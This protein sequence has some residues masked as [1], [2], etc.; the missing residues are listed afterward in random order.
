MHWGHAVSR[1]LVHWTELPIALYP[2]EYGDWCFSGSGVV[3]RRNT[4]GFGSAGSP[5]LVIA[6]TST[7]RGECIAYSQRSRSD[8]D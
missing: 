1:D 8:L 5:P 2:R 4:S 6:F 3:D 7:G